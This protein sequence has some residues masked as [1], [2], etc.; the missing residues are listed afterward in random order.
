MC[1]MNWEV[2]L[3]MCIWDFTCVVNCSECVSCQTLKSFQLK[4]ERPKMVT[5]SGISKMPNIHIQFVTHTPNPWAINFQWTKDYE[6]IGPQPVVHWKE[7]LQSS[8]LI[9]LN[10]KSI[11][12]NHSAITE[13]QKKYTSVN[14]H[15]TQPLSGSCLTTEWETKPYDTHSEQF[16]THVKS[17]MHTASNTSQFI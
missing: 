17:Q 15:K 14:N 4:I 6:P 9:E 8:L 1:Y 2:L 3:A 7:N 12:L 16:A 10:P 11:S 5:T 13:S